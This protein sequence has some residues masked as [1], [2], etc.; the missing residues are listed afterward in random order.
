MTELRKTKITDSDGDIGEI[1]QN[2]DEDTNL[3]G[4]YGQ[5]AD[6]VMYA[7]GAN[8]LVMPVAM[9][10]STHALETVSYAHHEIHDGSDYFIED[11]VDL[12]AGDYFDVQITTPD[13][14]AWAHV[15]FRLEAESETE[16]YLYEDVAI[17]TAGTTKTPRNSNRN[18]TNTSGLTVAVISNASES[19]AND[20]TDVAGATALMHGIIGAGS[21]TKGNNDHDHEIIFKQNED[22]S[23]RVIATASG[24]VDYSLNWY[25]HTDKD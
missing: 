12:S 2:A 17:S 24:Y 5:V 18:S 9:D 20:D 3:D 11:V 22:Y 16:W 10:K 21:Q 13:N 1:V 7:R 8:S 6:A 4:D 23:I 19:D 14:T 25:E 15:N